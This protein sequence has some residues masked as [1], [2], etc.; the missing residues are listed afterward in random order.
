MVNGEVAMGTGFA[1]RSSEQSDEY[2]IEGEDLSLIATAEMSLTGY[3]AGEILN[4]KDLP[5]FLRWIF[6]L[7]PKRGWYLW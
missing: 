3:H 2:F 1:P 5:I 6:S 4:E 7:L